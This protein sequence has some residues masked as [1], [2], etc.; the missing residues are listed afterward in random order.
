VHFFIIMVWLLFL[1]DVGSGYY[2]SDVFAFD[3]SH[4][5]CSNSCV[6]S[7]C[8]HIKHILY[9]DLIK[10]INKAD[11]SVRLRKAALRVA[12]KRWCLKAFSLQMVMGLY[13]PASLQ[14]FLRT[15]ACK[16]RVVCEVL[17]RC[18]CIFCF[19]GSV[20]SIRKN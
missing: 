4:Q 17:G 9:N 8:R 14:S 11:N 15:W 5:S 19:A 3:A 10:G 16:P 12:K 1:S 20:Y 18:V 7:Q 2:V 6:T 13:V